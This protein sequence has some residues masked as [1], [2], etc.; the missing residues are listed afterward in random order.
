MRFLCRKVLSRTSQVQR[1]RMQRNETSNNITTATADWRRKQTT[2]VNRISVLYR[3]G[4]EWI[5]ARS[6]IAGDHFRKPSHRALFFLF[7]PS[8]VFANHRLFGV[9]AFVVS[10][11]FAH[12][13]IYLLAGTLACSCGVFRSCGFRSCGFG[14]RVQAL[15]RRACAPTGQLVQVCPFFTLLRN[16]VGHQRVRNDAASAGRVETQSAR[17]VSGSCF[18]RVILSSCGAAGAWHL[19]VFQSNLV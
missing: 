19:L 3:L 6:S 4:S 17:R 8:P 13:G 18:A 1:S 10:V 9:V 12:R 14:R 7:Q 5:V 11:V 15:H 2:N 16:Q